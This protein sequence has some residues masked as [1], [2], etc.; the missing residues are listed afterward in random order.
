MPKRIYIEIDATEKRPEPAQTAPRRPLPEI[1]MPFNPYA[2]LIEAI[3]DLRPAEKAKPPKPAPAESDRK[4]I[5]ALKRLCEDEGQEKIA[6]ALGYS[7]R[8]LR[9]LLSSGKLA[10]EARDAMKGLLPKNR[11]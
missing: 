6:A 3:R 1:Y 9:R 11:T 7:A 4:L 2:A 8:H 5:R 10:P